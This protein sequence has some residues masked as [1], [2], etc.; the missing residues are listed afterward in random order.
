MRE[1]TMPE[2]IEIVAISSCGSERI[3]TTMRL[4]R[5]ARPADHLPR[6]NYYYA[7]KEELRFVRG[8]ICSAHGQE[9]NLSFRSS[10]YYV[11]EIYC[12]NDIGAAFAIDRKPNFEET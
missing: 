8:I 9:C 12:N 4:T 3:S 11:N 6:G 1:Y 2:T 7:S 5:G 10:D